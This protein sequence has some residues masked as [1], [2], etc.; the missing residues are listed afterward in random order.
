MKKVSNIAWGLILVIIGAILGLNAL[1]I[2]NFNIFF[3]GWWTLFII[4]PCFIGVIKDEEKTPSLIGVIIGFSLLLACQDIIN[5]ELIWKMFIPVIIVILGLKLIFS[6]GYSSKEEKRNIAKYKENKNMKECC[7]TF[8]SQK[9]IIDEEFKG[10]E[11]NAIFGGIEYDLRNAIINED[12]VINAT[13][14]FGGIDIFLP[15]DVNV[16]VNS[17][18]I[19]GSTDNKRS[20]SSKNNKVT[21]FIYTNSLFGGVEIK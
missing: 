7:S 13:A 9:V 2:T 12:V 1:G 10:A 17:T 4:V 20:S 6:N 21:I 11:L 15:K 19:F 14:I 18:S 16:K 5:F 3:E 8:S